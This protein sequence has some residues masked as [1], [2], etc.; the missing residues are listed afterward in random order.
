[1]KYALLALLAAGAAHGYE[2]KQR[3]ESRFG[4]AWPPVNIG[5]IYTT[6][7]RL[8]RDGLVCGHEVEQAGRPLKHVFEITGDG[9]RALAEWLAEATPSPRVRD[10]FF[11]KLVLSR[12]TGLSDPMAM[13]ERQRQAFLQEL[14][15]LNELAARQHGWTA[16]HLLIEGAVLHLQA[17]LKWLDLCE[18][19]LRDG[20]I[21]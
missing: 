5:Q 21:D 19:K 2:L 20:G 17:D 14:R 3:F 12:T 4:T 16:G 9:R 6:L 1:M 18:V 13:I 7:Q 15:D 10:E 8:E 11:L